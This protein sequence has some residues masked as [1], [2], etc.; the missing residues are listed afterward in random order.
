[1]SSYYQSCFSKLH[2]PV[3]YFSLFLKNNKSKK[4][5]LFLSDLFTETFVNITGIPV[6]L[7]K[8]DGST[9]AALGAG[10][11][12]GIF[13]SPAEAFS[14]MEKLKVVEPK[15]NLFEDIYQD[16]KTLLEIQLKK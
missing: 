5:N 16:W 14:N 10:I 8:N 15:R 11:G 2:F 7:Y 1:M 4:N 3:L 6:E 13:R 12:A 9:G